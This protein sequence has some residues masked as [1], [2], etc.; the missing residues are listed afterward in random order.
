MPHP[1]SP[2]Q[3]KKKAPSFQQLWQSIGDVMTDMP[4]L[5]SRGNRPLQMTFEP[6]LQSLIYFHLQEH[7]SARYLLQDLAED[8]FARKYIAPP[9]GIKKSS[10]SEA[11]NTRG[12]EQLSYA[13]ERLR[14]KATQVL[15]T[16]HTHLGD[17]VAIDGSLIDAVM[18]MRWADYRKGAKKAKVH[19]GFDLNHAIPAK[20]FFT[21]GKG[22]ERPFV[23]PILSPGQTGVL[24]RYYQ[25]HRNFDLWQDEGKYF[26]CRIKA[27]TKKTIPHASEITP[28]GLVCF[29][30]V[31]HL[32]HP[33]RNQTIKPVR[34]IGYRIGG[35]EYWV[36]TNCFDLAAEDLALIYK[37]RWEIENFFGWWKQHLQVYH[38][39]AR[40]EYGF[41]VQILAG[42]I[43]YLLLA[44]YCRKHHQE[45]VSIRR[46]RELR[47]KIQNEAR[48]LDFET[49]DTQAKLHF[50]QAKT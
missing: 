19:L 15:P 5:E 28:G 22:D 36:A 26:V 48:D 11:I 45:K 18:S 31:V 2:S 43:T 23:S 3:S 33:Y 40:S 38:L 47:I 41:M 32:G 12:L 4:P 8:D 30:A 16:E 50:L 21:N 7:E 49:P 17:L 24:D 14:A 13:Y 25:G 39:I 37:L 42:L 27:R 9:Q 29:D 6:Q 35:A 44:I 10:S 34:L 46:V 20:I 1:L